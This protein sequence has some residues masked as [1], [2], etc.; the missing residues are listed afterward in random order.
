MRN[1]IRSLAPPNAVFNWQENTGVKVGIDQ[2][3]RRPL[4]EKTSRCTLAWI[5]A[6]SKTSESFDSDVFNNVED[7]KLVGRVLK[8]CD[9]SLLLADKIEIEL[10]VGLHN[11]VKLTFTGRVLW[12][13]PVA[14]MAPKR[15]YK[16]DHG[17]PITLGGKIRRG[18]SNG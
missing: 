11:N 5:E 9:K 3:T 12:S 1:S 8:C 4:F 7:V 16:Q 15:Q 10:T 17:I 2:F 14:I 13:N 6:N 18:W